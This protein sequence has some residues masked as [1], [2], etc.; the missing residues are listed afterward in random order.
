[1]AMLITYA[2]SL[3]EALDPYLPP[4]VKAVSIITSARILRLLF[5]MRLLYQGYYT[6]EEEVRW[7]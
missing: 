6:P 5:L 7:C 4:G 1:M 3:G 2:G